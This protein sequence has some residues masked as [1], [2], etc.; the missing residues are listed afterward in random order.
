M[1]VDRKNKKYSAPKIKSLET[2]VKK[3]QEAQEI[4]LIL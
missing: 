2:T 4:I 3:I 1:T